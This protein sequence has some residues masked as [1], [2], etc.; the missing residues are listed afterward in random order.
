MT[1]LYT[2]T[3]SVL[4]NYFFTIQPTKANSHKSPITYP[5]EKE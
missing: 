1:L 5:A 2:L 4:S 3:L